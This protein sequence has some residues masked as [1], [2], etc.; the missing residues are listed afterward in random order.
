MDD[1]K[2][3]KI[4]TT[5]SL[6]I[7]II[8]FS[9][10]VFE[11]MYLRSPL[12]FA[13]P[14]PPPIEMTF[15]PPEEEPTQH[16]VDTS[17]PATAPV[18]TN[19]RIAMQDA[20]AA[21]PIPGTGDAATPNMENVGDRETLG[22]PTPLKPRPSLET[23]QAVDPSPQQDA[24]EP[25]EETQEE[26]PKQE[27]QDQPEDPKKEAKPTK[28]Q[29]KTEPAND[30][31][32]IVVAKLE[33]EG[34]QAKT[35]DESP[36]SELA[37]AQEAQPQQPGQAAQEPKAPA[38]P[39]TSRAGG[40]KA[41]FLNFEAMQSEIAPYLKEIQSRVEKRWRIALDMKYRGNQPTAAVV[42]CAIGPDGKLVFV[43][44]ID[45]GKT[46]GYAH[47][48]K[49]A[50]ELAAPFPPFPFKVPEMYKDKNLEIRWTFNFM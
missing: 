6:V 22:A 40:A 21:S 34:T 16:L 20:N 50:I 8:L 33:P 13:P 46:L 39:M 12:T 45:A 49:E 31:G 38:E 37:Q 29:Q 18:Q 28:A 15:A 23:A 11:V 43:N 1:K 3:Y 27:P 4:A 47:V 10:I 19:E 2:R 14:A 9:L 41:G 42:D 32:A 7:H 5:A 30:E 17:T 24:Q 44:I 26:A 25:Q 36:I 35:L 48:C